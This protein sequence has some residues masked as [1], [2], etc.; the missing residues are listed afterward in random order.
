MGRFNL[1]FFIVICPHRQVQ[2]IKSK[3]GIY[4]SRERRVGGG[5][6]CYCHSGDCK[7]FT[8]MESLGSKN[9]REHA[10][11]P[12]MLVKLSLTP[13]LMV[14]GSCPNSSSGLH[15]CTLPLDSFLQLHW[16]LLF[17][18]WFGPQSLCICCLL[19]L[20]VLSGSPWGCCDLSEKS[21]RKYPVLGWSDYFRI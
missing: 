9:A 15:C 4:E 3:G 12:R 20:S 2:D 6:P 13:L 11:R 1:S 19:C 5:L 18:E 21:C 8:G 16:P 14:P 7:V 17:L 10:W